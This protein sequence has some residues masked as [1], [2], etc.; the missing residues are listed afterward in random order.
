MKDMES[1]G[2]WF[3]FP[4]S[5]FHLQ[6]SD[7]HIR[8]RSKKGLHPSLYDLGLEW[9][10]VDALLYCYQLVDA[11]LCGSPTGTILRSLFPLRS[12]DDHAQL[13][14]EQMRHPHSGPWHGEAVYFAPTDYIDE[15][16][17]SAGPHN[18]RD[19]SSEIR[20]VGHHQEHRVFIISSDTPHLH[21]QDD[22]P[23]WASM[24]PA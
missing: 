14:G 9:P 24:H 8:G 20:L 11:P 3:G 21:A 22:K 16:A 13:A 10:K 5:A 12:G 1:Q 15:S 4:R 17:D 18:Q 19:P 2:K 23:E 6:W 7:H